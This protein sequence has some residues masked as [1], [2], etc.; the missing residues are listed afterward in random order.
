MKFLAFE[1]IPLMLI[2]AMILLYL[3]IT[4]KSMIERIF[5]DKLLA[6][7]RVDQG[8]PRTLRIVL[9]F[10]A[11][12]LMILAMARPVYQKGVVEV[13]GK[14]SDIVIALDIS[15]SMKAKDLFPD[16]LAF[17]KR[18]VEEFIKRSKGLGIGL[19]AF[20]RDAYII[21]PIS[22]DKS[23]LLYLLHRL[24]TQVLQLQGTDI[25]A[26]LKSAKLLFGS[27]TPREVLLVT[28]G[29]D[30]KDFSRAITFAKD[31]DMHV[32]ILGIGTKE[33]APIPDNEG[34]VKKNG[35]IVIVPLNTHIAKLAEATGGLFVQATL[36]SEDIK[37]LLARY[38]GMSKADVHEK[39]VDQ[40]EFY[41]YLLFFA[42]LFLFL[43]F[44][45]LPHKNIAFVVP[46]L[47]TAHLHAGIT[48]FKLIKEA[49]AAYARGNYK[50]AVHLFGQIAASKGS[51]QSYYDLGN[52]L[53]K[54]GRYQEA[55]RAYAKVQTSDKELEFRKLFNMGNSYMK[56]RNC[57]KAIAMYQKALSIHPKDADARS[58]LAL[59]KQMCA[60]KKNKQQQNRSQKK[61]QP[62]KKQQQQ[63]QQQKSGQK[64][65]KQK[66]RQKSQK[67]QNAQKGKAKPKNQPI[68]DREEK[69]WLKRI[70]KQNAPTMLFPA[71]QKI[72]KEGSNENP[73]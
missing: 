34:F 41:P 40:T 39:I 24:D 2:P 51:A 13:T 7:L 45:D 63:K 28:D 49:K 62:Q 18:K 26:A 23:S 59:A 38:E 68:S 22:G 65:Q 29:G 66:Q 61:Q 21:S 33:G 6:K 67:H 15:R 35:K 30:A 32:S 17:A 64:S 54:A 71:V 36:G 37:K 25:L 60:K 48:D 72:Q 20:A 70:E 47:F 16:R 50:E 43:S 9:L 19:V 58:N 14:R 27:H 10:L 42:L 1:F 4:N 44:F 11:L 53:Y 8:L 56:L 55:L 69:K 3:V 31:T 46:L 5:D 57:K 73:W 12:F 52:A